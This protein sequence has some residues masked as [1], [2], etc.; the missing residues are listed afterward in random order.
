[1]INKVNPMNVTVIVIVLLCFVQGC[2]QQDNIDTPTIPENQDQCVTPIN[3]V[4]VS[5]SSGGISATTDGSRFGVATVFGVVYLFN[6][7]GAPLMERDGIGSSY[8]FLLSNGKWL[9]AS[10]YNKEESWKSTLVKLDA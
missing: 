8:A 2:L 3:K 1:M 9:L 5:V 10:R 7:A 6:D 4:S